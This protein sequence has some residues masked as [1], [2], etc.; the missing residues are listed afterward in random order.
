MKRMR[1]SAESASC[2]AL[3]KAK[4]PGVELHDLGE[5]GHKIGETV[6]ARI[7]MI[8]V[9]HMFVL[10]LLV[11]RGGALFKTVIIILPAIEING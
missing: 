6:V 11:K 9:L 8:F 4:C 7:Q 1:G 5:V 2:G 3:L 10:Q